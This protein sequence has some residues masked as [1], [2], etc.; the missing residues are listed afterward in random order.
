MPGKTANCPNCGAPVEFLWSAAIQTT[1]PFCKSVIVRRDVDLVKVGEMADL[2]PDAS[3]IQIATEGIYQKKTFVVVGRILYEYER[4]GWNEWHI[5]FNDG[6]SGWLSDAQAEY[7][8]SFLRNAPS[9]LPPASGLQPGQTFN[10]FGH[11]YSVTVVTPA[12][13]RGVEGELPFEY[14]NKQEVPFADLLTTDARFATIDYSDTNPIL[15][16]GEAVEYDD[17]HLKN[18]RIFE[19]WH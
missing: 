13:Y 2:P 10:W 19:G 16:I 12:E 4:G 8:V 14:W 5:I 17:L 1:C 7:A 3:P 11:E 9:A 18:V 6:T 15:F